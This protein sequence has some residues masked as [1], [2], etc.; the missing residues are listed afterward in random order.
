VIS[1]ATSSSGG[2]TE[3]VAQWVRRCANGL[4]AVERDEFRA[5]LKSDPEHRGAFARANISGVD[6]DWAW[7]TDAVDE[8]LVGLTARARRRQRRRTIGA[9]MIA[10][11]I[12]AGSA[13]QWNRATAPVT[14][15]PASNLVVVGPESM[16][17]P[18]G[19]VVELKDGAQ[20]KVD[21]SDAIRTVTLANGTAYFHVA[22]NPQRPFVVS[23]GGMAV[24]AVGTAFTVDLGQKEMTVLVTEGRVR[25]DA[26]AEAAVPNVSLPDA[27]LASVGA[28]NSVVLP[29]AA[30][31]AGP[32][33]VRE[34]AVAEVREQTGWR[35]P[36]LE[37][38]RTPLREVVAQM[39]QHNQK[40]F[41]LGDDVVGDLR[42]S[43]ILRADK[44]ETLTESLENDFGVR[45]DRRDDKVVLLRSK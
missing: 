13:W 35:I 28:G 26:A 2:I 42:V 14:T 24:R 37:F 17:L 15:P 45:V 6:C 27:P 41:E 32:P 36:K 33:V 12:F 3:P 43:G 11:L 8:I 30:I 31:N 23:A 4:S 1:D 34:L 18:D 22:K 5:W 20:V 39:N 16:T 10:A 19:S 38:S 21:F 7:Q 25:V 44:I 40:K 9:T 29:V